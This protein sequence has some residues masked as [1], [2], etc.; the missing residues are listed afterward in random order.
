MTLWLPMHILKRRIAKLLSYLLSK[1]LICQVWEYRLW[2]HYN[3]SRNLSNLFSKIQLAHQWNYFT[4]SKFS[5][6]V[7][8]PVTHL[9][10]SSKLPQLIRPLVRSAG[11]G[12]G[13]EMRGRSCVGSPCGR[14]QQLS[15]FWKCQP[16]PKHDKKCI[17][18]HQSF[19]KLNG[20]C[21]FEFWTLNS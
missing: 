9:S 11:V 4:S 18:S 15:Y 2:C 17:I 19:L 20:I 7:K 3:G 5:W 8:R 10:T 13:A 6:C 12:P 21:K 14:Q 16:I 1:F